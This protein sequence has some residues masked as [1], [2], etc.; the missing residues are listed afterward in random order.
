MNRNTPQLAGLGKFSP[1]QVAEELVAMQRE[2]EFPNAADRQPA[3]SQDWL[4]KFADHLD[5]LRAGQS[6]QRILVVWGLSQSEAARRFGVSRQALHKWLAR[7][8]PAER[9]ES[10]ADLAAATD[11]LVRYLKRQRV[12]AVV[13]RPMSANNQQSLLDLLG[14]GKTKAV[15]DACRKMFDFQAAQH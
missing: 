3:L 2:D 10:V 13:R 6:L 1:K 15:L 4:D 7:G 14:Q 9:V 12:P 5:A 11:L 8:A